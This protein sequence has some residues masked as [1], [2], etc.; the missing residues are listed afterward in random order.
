MAHA[1]VPKELRRK[2]DDRSEKC[3]FLGH[4]DQSKAY[5]LYNMVTKKVIINMD[6]EFNENKS[7]DGSINMTISIG[8][9]PQ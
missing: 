4:S 8:V 1:H 2:L 7:C 3:I 5:K 6:I 9:I